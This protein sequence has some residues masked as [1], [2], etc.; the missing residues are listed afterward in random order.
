MLL[1]KGLGELMYKPVPLWLVG[2]GGLSAWVVFLPSRKSREL[3]YKSLEGT[4]GPRSSR[5]FRLVARLPFY[6]V[7]FPCGLQGPESPNHERSTIAN[8]P[9]WMCA[10]DSKVIWCMQEFQALKKSPFL[11]TTWQGMG[12]KIHEEYL[13]KSELE[14]FLLNLFSCFFWGGAVWV[15]KREGGAGASGIQVKRSTM[16]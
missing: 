14:N 4:Q 5:R 11:V 13:E 12:E 16:D 9:L 2:P 8:S 10:R 7:M 1:D 6:R 15:F 3:S